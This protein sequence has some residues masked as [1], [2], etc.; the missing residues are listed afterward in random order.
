ME[1]IWLLK[2]VLLGFSI[3]APVGPIGIICIRRTLT[4]GMLNGFTAGLGAATADAFYGSAA[5]FGLTFIT[6]LF[7]ENS[8][9]LRIAGS[10]FLF[11]L[12]CSTFAGDPEKQKEATCPGG[13]LHA[14]F[15]TF[16]LTI[17]N[18]MTILSFG[19]VFAG[20]G[21]ADSKGEQLSSW[22]LIAGVFLGSSVWWILLSGMIQLLRQRLDYQKL[23]Y[24]NRLSGIVILGFAVISLLSF[25]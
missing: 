8:L 12:G 2:G 11:Y 9:Y 14:Y 24:L 22:L 25:L 15:S 13:W 7:L 6:N 4:R 17:A 19:A 21:I 10:G 3:A 20:L 18:P 5:A 23:V 16:F 1:S